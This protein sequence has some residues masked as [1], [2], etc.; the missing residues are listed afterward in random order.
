MFG[1]I[2]S[3]QNHGTHFAWAK[4]AHI[5]QSG[6]NSGPGFRVK[7]AQTFEVFPSS[8]SRSFPLFARER[9]A[10][11]HHPGDNPGENRWSVGSTPVQMLPPRGSNCGRLPCDLPLGCLQGGMERSGVGRG[12]E[13]F[14]VLRGVESHCGLP[15][16]CRP[17]WAA[18]LWLYP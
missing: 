6:S 8:L 14:P 11:A 3:T 9:V 12:Q 18:R 4:S 15:G 17:I 5:R 7:V 16:H 2:C 1:A 13:R 10:N